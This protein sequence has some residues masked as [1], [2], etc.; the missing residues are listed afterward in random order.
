[1]LA[2]AASYTET[3][4]GHIGGNLMAVF[5]NGMSLSNALADAVERAA[6]YT[7]LVDA[8]RRLPLSG[9]IFKPGL[10]LTADHGIEREEEIKVLLPGGEQVS[11]ALAGRDR[12]SDLAVLRLAEGSSSGTGNPAGPAAQEVRVGHMVLAVGRPDPDGPQAT[13]GL[14]NALGGG[15]RTHHGGVIDRYIVTDAT[16]LPGFSGGPLVDLSGALLGINT[17]GLVRGASL[18][19]AARVALQTADALAEHGHVRRGYLGIR[20]QV[21]EL[22]AQAAAAL[23]RQQAAGLL[24]V[25]LESD[26]PSASGLMVGDILVGINGQ[27]VANHDDLLVR[28][29]GDLVGRQAAVEVLR[30]GQPQT[31]TV[32]V[33]D[34]E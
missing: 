16:P 18:A 14:V 29:T 33:G 24:L 31:V 17:S 6:G 4:Q 32:T 28:L 25:G 7:V 22:S 30:G 26:G 10:V 2:L 13:L 3:N 34:R 1:V 27:P 8:R 15:L 20:S 9:V 5:E 19:I 23:G 11:A 12:G 21:V